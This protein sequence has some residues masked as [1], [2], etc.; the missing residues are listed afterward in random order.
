MKNKFYVL[1][2]AI[3]IL[4]SCTP[5]N[6][7][8]AQALKS[9]VLQNIIGGKTEAESLAAGAQEAKSFNAIAQHMAMIVVQKRDAQGNIDPYG[10]GASAV[11]LAPNLIVTSAHT[12][13]GFNMSKG[14]F[15]KVYFG[16]SGEFQNRPTYTFAKADIV[17][18]NT[19]EMAVPGWKLQAGHK[20]YVFIFIKS[21]VPRGFTGMKMMNDMNFF[22]KDA[23][24]KAAGFG[25]SGVNTDDSQLRVLDTTISRWNINQISE[26]YSPLPDG[27]GVEDK[28]YFLELN[29]HSNSTVYK[30]DSGGAVYFE[31]K[32]E[33]GEPD[34]FLAG[35]I[36]AHRGF[37]TGMA[38]YSLRVDAFYQDAIEVA[39][40]IYGGN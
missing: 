29:A 16:S 19:D 8:N 38:N 36:S 23:H 31:G 1:I 7:P 26:K 25:M 33:K 34:L 39:K 20:D 13:E 40:K 22:K 3:N 12:F 18:R 17:D 9:G 5:Q 2:A 30:E 35:I 4:S 10:A 15:G 21:G 28:K 24:Y 11:I 6:T 14:Q 27:I 37:P 32:D